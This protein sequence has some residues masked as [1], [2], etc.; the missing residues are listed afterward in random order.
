MTI[1]LHVRSSDKDQ[2][3]K[4]A[5]IQAAQAVLD[6][7]DR[8]GDQEVSIIITDDEQLRQLNRNFRGSDETTDV[9]AF[10]MAQVDPDS[11]KLYLGDILISL[12]QAKAQAKLHGNSLKDELQLLVVHGTLHLLGYDHVDPVDKDRMWEAQEKILR[13]YAPSIQLPE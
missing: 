13:R 2:I 8:N 12:E 5:L 4:K 10:P 6:V 3:D 11:G 9:L 7:L 1:H